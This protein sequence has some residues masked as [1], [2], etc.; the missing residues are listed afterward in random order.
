[1][2]CVWQSL[3]KSQEPCAIHLK[4]KPKCLK[5]KTFGKIISRVSKATPTGENVN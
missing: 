1:M 2:S 4:I 5:I 3:I